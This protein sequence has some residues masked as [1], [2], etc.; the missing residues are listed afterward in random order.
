MRPKEEEE[1]RSSLHFG[2]K[3]RKNT[4]NSGKLTEKYSK[5]EKSHWKIR[6]NDKTRKIHKTRENTSET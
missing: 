3:I 1:K 4:H 2:K 6:K 5:F